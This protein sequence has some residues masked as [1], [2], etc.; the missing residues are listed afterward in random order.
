MW[1]AY[2]MVHLAEGQ[3]SCFDYVDKAQWLVVFHKILRCPRPADCWVLGM[4][5]IIW[6]TSSSDCRTVAAQYI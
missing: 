4:L 6:Y 3:R 2:V 5:R 1:P